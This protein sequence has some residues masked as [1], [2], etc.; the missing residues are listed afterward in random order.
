MECD[1]RE[2]LWVKIN[3]KRLPRKYSTL[4]IG[5]MYHPPDADNTAMTEYLMTSVDFVLRKHPE[6]GIILMGDFNCFNDSFM[7]THYGFVQVVNTPTRHNAILDKVWTNMKP[8][9]Q[10]PNILSQLGKSD[11][12]MV[13]LK[14][15]D[16]SSLDT[17]TVQ[18]FRMRCMGHAERVQFAATLATVKWEPLYR[19]DTCQEQFIYFQNT[20]QS[21]IA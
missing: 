7:G 9:Y 2:V 14:P 17:G 19:L 13:L 10:S 12:N 6:S 20:M 18:K 16:H 11:H 15:S 4:L 21:L 1:K 8:V 5:C 3:P